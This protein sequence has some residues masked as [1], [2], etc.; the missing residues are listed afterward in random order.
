MNFCDVTTRLIPITFA[1]W[2]EIHR[3]G[4]PVQQHGQFSRPEQRHE[5]GI[6]RDRCGQHQPD[7]LAGQFRESLRHQARAGQH[8]RV[9]HDAGEIVRGG[10]LVRM[11]DG[12]PHERFEDGRR[13]HGERR[14]ARPRAARSTS[15]A[16]LIGSPLSAST[17]PWA[18]APSS[19]TVVATMSLRKP[20][21][22]S[23]V[24]ARSIRSRLSRPRFSSSVAGCFSVVGQRALQFFLEDF[25]ARP[26]A[27]PGVIFSSGTSR[28]ASACG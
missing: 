10:G 27:S 20:N 14:F 24:C 8:A 19:P 23:M 5:R 28:A 18:S 3:A 11:R 12:L 22:C 15:G 26:A 2:F 9:G 13:G 6:R 4:R 1:A 17:R 25:D 16:I 7:R 21:R